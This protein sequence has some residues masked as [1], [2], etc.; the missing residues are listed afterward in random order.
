ME[1][2]FPF[3]PLLYCNTTVKNTNKCYYYH[4][5]LLN[6]NI[7]KIKDNNY[8]KDIE[9]ILDDNLICETTMCC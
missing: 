6:F 4:N 3:L 1:H 9:Y 8:M 5:F 7:K 2:Y